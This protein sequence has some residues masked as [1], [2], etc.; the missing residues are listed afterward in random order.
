MMGGVRSI[1]TK[2]FKNYNFESRVH[3]ELERRSDKPKVAPRHKSINKGQTVQNIN[4]PDEEIGKKDEALDKMLQSVW[5]DSKGPPPPNPKDRPLPEEITVKPFPE[6]GIAEP[7]NIPPGKLSIRQALDMISKYQSNPKT[8]NSAYLAN[9]YKLE[10]HAT[11]QIL[12]HFQTFHMHI[13]KK[14]EERFPHLLDTLKAKV[15]VL[16]SEKQKQLL[17]VAKDLSKSE[18][19]NLGKS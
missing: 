3:K 15:L 14:M 19:K 5:V 11:Q 12:R 9:E 4:L 1:L 18:R 17:D 13:P 7:K 8:F 16:E 10:L 2:P 6:Y